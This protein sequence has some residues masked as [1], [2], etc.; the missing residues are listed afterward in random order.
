MITLITYTDRNMTISATRCVNTAIK[1]G[2][3]QAVIYTPDM[4]NHDFKVKNA[5]IW[6]HGNRGADCFWLFKPW[7]IYDMMGTMSE[8]DILIY[9]DAGCEFINS[10]HYIIDRMDKDYFFM[11]NGF[12]HV[13]WCKE[14][15]SSTIIG[16][17]IWC[18]KSQIQASLLFFRV[19]NKTK[20]FVKE[21]L[22]FCQ[23]PGFIDD[24]PST[25]EN[26]NSFSDHR[27]D[28]AVLTS[29]AIKHGIDYNNLWCDKIWENQR[30]RWPHCTY[31]PIVLHHRKRNHEWK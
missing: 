29:C 11:T 8:G 18:D 25:K 10:V 15:V 7:I 27:H 12:N 24:S 16:E 6:Q 30:Y 2:V 23:M 28:Q 31:P 17:K 22:L 21:W 26:Y 20:A 4:V 9:S 3:D 19:N 14:N 5:D 1:N 13:D